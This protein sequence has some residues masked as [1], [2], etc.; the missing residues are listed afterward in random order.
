MWTELLQKNGFPFVG[1]APM[2]RH[3]SIGVGGAVSAYME[4]EDRESLIRAIDLCRFYQIPFRVLGRGTNVIAF[5][6]PMTQIVICTRK[7]NA[8]TKNKAYITAECGASLRQLALFALAQ[9]M[10]GFA[11]LL[12]IPG[13]VGA[14]VR[15]NAGAF[16]DF[17]CQHLAQVEVYDAAKHRVRSILADALSY[18]YRSSFLVQARDLF[19]LS[20][21]FSFP[22]GDTLREQERIRECRLARTKTQPLSSRS[23][24]SVFRR[25]EGVGAGVYLEKA[26]CKGLCRGGAQ[27]SPQHANFIVNVS[28]ATA[29]DVLFLIDEARERVYRAF[30][31]LLVPEAEKII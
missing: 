16:G 27:I 8:L 21:T 24:G 26:G 22:M 5:D 30:G 15:G 18:G 25:Y 14:A 19:L 20:A 17:I 9:G 2:T 23:C 1:N 29:D 13:S 28:S 6:R 12:D 10:V 11:G 4:P 31:I 7:L 3:T